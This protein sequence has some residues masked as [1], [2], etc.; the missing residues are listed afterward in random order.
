MLTAVCK[1]QGKGFVWAEAGQWNSV[2]PGFCFLVAVVDGGLMVRAQNLLVMVFFCSSLPW[3]SKL[4]EVL[5]V[6]KVTGFWELLTAG[7]AIQCDG[8]SIRGGGGS[9]IQWIVFSLEPTDVLL[10]LRAGI[11]ITQLEILKCSSLGLL[12]NWLGFCTGLSFSWIVLVLQ[13]LGGKLLW[14]LLRKEVWVVSESVDLSLWRW[15]Q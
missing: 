8:S 1:H 13:G 10:H 6:V 2:I 5:H 11:K 15:W 12:L 7:E 3:Q 14:L 9:E 4:W